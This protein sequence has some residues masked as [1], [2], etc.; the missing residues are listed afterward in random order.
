MEIKIIKGKESKVYNFAESWN[1][2]RMNQYMELM[3]IL[4]EDKSETERIIDMIYCLSDIPKEDCWNLTIPQIGQLGGI[5]TEFLKTKPNNKLNHYLNIGKVKYGFHPNLSDITMGEFVD[6]ESYIKDGV[7]KNLHK[8]LSVLYRPIIKE[9]GEKYQIEPYIPNKD[10]AEL[11]KD[12]LTV[13]DFNGASVFFLNL[14][15][16]LLNHS[17]NSLMQ[18]MGKRKTLKV[19]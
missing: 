10:R 19:D 3:N 6:I 7:N 16:E 4:K 9:E 15:K 18:K 17:A 13:G 5:V 2:L 8:I 14:G 12:T 11:F 1:Q